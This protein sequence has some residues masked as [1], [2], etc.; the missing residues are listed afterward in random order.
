[1]KIKKIYPVS[2]WGED[3]EFN[4]L[5]ELD[6]EIIK[7]ENAHYYEEFGFYYADI[8]FSPKEQGE[9][10]LAETYNGRFSIYG[11]TFDTP[12]EGETWEADNG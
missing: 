5:V 7:I 8:W 6:R 4:A 12:F 1:M 10:I 11:V 2:A 3:E 9:Y